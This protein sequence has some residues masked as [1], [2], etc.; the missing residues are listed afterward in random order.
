MEEDTGR[1]RKLT[2]IEATEAMGI[3]GE[4]VRKRIAGITLPTIK[5]GGT[6]YILLSDTDRTREDDGLEGLLDSLQR[7]DDPAATL[8]ARSGERA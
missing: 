7:R 1:T 8:A 3:T 6:V 2:I 4:A 5:E